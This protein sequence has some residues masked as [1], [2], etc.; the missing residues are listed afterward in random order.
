MNRS[1]TAAA[2]QSGTSEPGQPREPAVTTTHWCHDCQ[3]EVSVI[4]VDEAGEIKC[5]YNLCFVI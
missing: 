2:A 5:K 3:A 4:K 1:T